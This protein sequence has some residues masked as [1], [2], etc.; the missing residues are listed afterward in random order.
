MRLK[1]PGIVLIFVCLVSPLSGQA[2]VQDLYRRGASAQ[3]RGDF[4]TALEL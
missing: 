1:S 2:E 4:Y 3:E